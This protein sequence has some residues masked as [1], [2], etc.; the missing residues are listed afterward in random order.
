VA[1]A[2]QALEEALRHVPRYADVHKALGETC[3]KAGDLVRAEQAYR[4]ALVLNANFT[5]A[6]LALAGVLARRGATEARDQVREARTY[7]PLNPRA[8]AMDDRRLAE[9]LEEGVS[10]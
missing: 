9:L 1:E 2:R 10:S 5:E 8:R 3:E 4:D 6:R 7:D